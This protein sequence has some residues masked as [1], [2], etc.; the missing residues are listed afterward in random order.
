MKKIKI[1]IV[2]ILFLLLILLVPASIALLRRS[3]FSQGSIRTSAWSVSMNDTLS[4]DNISI[5]PGGLANG[6]YT[7]SV[8]SNSEVDATYSIVVSNIPNN[9]EIKLDNGSFQTPVNGTV[10]FANAGTILY[11][12][13]NKERSHSITFKANSNA[14]TSNNNQINI[15]VEIRQV[16]V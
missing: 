2:I 5:T 13:Q 6:T 14:T 15:N 8:T 7:F 10:T 4:N 3:A 9:V 16:L 12:D 11:S 1:E